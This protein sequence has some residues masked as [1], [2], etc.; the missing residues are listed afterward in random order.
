MTAP[1]APFG[2]VLTAMVTPFTAGGDLDLD[3]AAALAERLVQQGNDGLVV[4][5]TTGESPTTSRE[6]KAALVRA[7]V[8]AV[9]DR[10]H[11]LAGVGGNDTEHVVELSRDAEKA[12]A[13]GLLS[14]T[15]YYNRPPDDGLVAHYE[16]SVAATD[17]PVMLYDIPVRTGLALSHAVLLR[18]AALPQVVAVKD[19][20]DDLQ[21]MSRLLA[22]TDLAVYAGTDPLTLPVLALGGVGV[23]S[24]VSHVVT[25]QLV[26][27]VRAYDAGDVER[28]RAVNLALQP[29]FTGMYRTQ[30]VILAKAALALAGLPVG[31]VRLPFVD[32][33]PEQVDRLRTDLQGVLPELAAAVAR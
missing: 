19:A 4:N 14:V 1:T 6:E 5:G 7:V 8:D 13:H 16:R 22:E 17:L 11:V 3:M 18:L 33:T 25:P 24:V 27:L 12:G 10:A 9:G 15:P 30:G 2:R 20:K 28:A 26:E 21:A 23:V 31:P 32:A 29:V